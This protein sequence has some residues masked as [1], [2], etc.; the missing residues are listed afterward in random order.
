MPI[1]WM[2]TIVLLRQH[3]EK[4]ASVMVVY[5]IMKQEALIQEVVV[6]NQPEIVCLGKQVADVSTPNLFSNF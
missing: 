5:V 6:Q 4:Q 1:A 3:P 2:E